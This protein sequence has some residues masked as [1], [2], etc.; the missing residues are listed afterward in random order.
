MAQFDWKHFY[1]AFAKALLNYK[2]NRSDLI[3]IIKTVYE[4]IGINLPTLERDNQI[5]DI[6]PFTVFGLFNKSKLKESNRVKIIT[7][8][9]KELA[10]GAAIPTSFDAVPVLNNQNATFYYWTGDRGPDD[11]DHLWDFFESALE[12]VKAPSDDKRQVVSK[13]FDLAINMKGNG[14][15]KITMGLYWIA[16]DVFLNLDSRNTWYIYESGK[17]PV[18]VVDSLPQIEQKISAD[19]Y[20]EIAEKLQIYLQS[21]RSTL[22]D[23]K[24]LS[25]EAWRYSEQVNQENRAIKVQ[26]QRDDKGSALADEN[27]DTIHYWIYSPGDRAYK[28]DEFYKAGIMAIR[29]GEIGDL[30][31][32]ASK[33][34]I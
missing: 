9:A 34:E 2:D 31:V 1:K 3:Q 18:D 8:F 19:K 33:E 32:F 7:A 27:V 15:S 29:W 25:F 30:Q 4:E 12:Y 14:N 17:L 10:V 22:K 24:E 13:Y 21:E 5:V 23:F 20:F 16:P 28:W 6:D 11:M 26:S